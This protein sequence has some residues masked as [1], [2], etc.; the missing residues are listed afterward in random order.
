MIKLYFQG[1]LFAYKLYEYE[2]VDVTG[3]KLPY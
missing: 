2:F 3:P 1:D